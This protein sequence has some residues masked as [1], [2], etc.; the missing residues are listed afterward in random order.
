MQIDLFACVFFRGQTESSAEL[1]MYYLVAAT[2][3]YA[4]S[5]FRL[6]EQPQRYPCSE[7]YSRSCGMILGGG[8]GGIK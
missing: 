1:K 2:S 6:K 7:Q 8:G 3:E 5:K 4:D